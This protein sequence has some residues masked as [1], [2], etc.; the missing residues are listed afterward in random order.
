M[1]AERDRRVG[2]A[3]GSVGSV[4]LSRVG[5]VARGRAAIG[6][7]EILRFVPLPCRAAPFGTIP[8]SDSPEAKDTGAPQAVKSCAKKSRSNT[9]STSRLH[10]A[11]VLST[12]A[13]AA[14]Q[15]WTATGARWG[16]GLNVRWVALLAF[17][18]AAASQPATVRAA[19]LMPDRPYVA[20][21]R[22][23][24]VAPEP[25]R[26]SIFIFG[27]RMSAGSIGETAL[28]NLTLDGQ[29]RWDNYIV[30][31]AYQRD[32]WRWG[33]IIFGLEVG[34]ADRFG[35]YESCCKPPV[36]S[37]SVLHAGEL[38]GGFVMRS[39]G[40]LLF[41]KVR[42]AISSTTGLS[43]ITKAIGR[44][45]EREV[46]L[47]ANPRVLFYWGP[48][49]TL[50]HVSMPNVELVMRLHHRSG[51]GKTLGGLNEGYNAWVGGFRFRF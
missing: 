42:L 8:C 5:T 47:D 20:P 26:N 12:V 50:S 48:E 2:C 35:R 13:G 3:G 36:R 37:D 23:P 24:V 45:R 25:A 46:T 49:L 18:G 6:L 33:P 34:V 16:L 10:R 9:K 22:T 7:A 41:N 19:D 28:F 15:G 40:L 44:E 51:A 27:G 38:W 30:G 29:Q 1:T 11:V 17:V 14:R 43:A 4:R 39:E 31:G 21:A 32:V